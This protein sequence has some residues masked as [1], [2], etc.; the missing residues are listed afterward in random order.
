MSIPRAGNPGIAVG[1]SELRA[2]AADEMNER[3]VDRSVTE[4]RRLRPAGKRQS[5]DVRDQAPA[6]TAPSVGLVDRDPYLDRLAGGA[7]ACLCDSH[8]AAVRI[9]GAEQDGPGR[10]G[11][12]HIAANSR[13]RYRILKAIV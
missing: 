8:D 1:W 10:I 13:I 11:P 7:R 9:K 3:C 4:F 6:Q 2:E 5:H 12:A